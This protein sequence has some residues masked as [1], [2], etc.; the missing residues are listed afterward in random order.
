VVL[1]QLVCKLLA[2]D[3]KV[4]IMAVVQSVDA[5]HRAS[6]RLGR[7]WFAASVASVT[8]VPPLSKAV[9][10]RQSYLTINVG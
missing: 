2:D 3:N 4:V 5:C 10:V 9:V 7:R 8:I 6:R 1:A